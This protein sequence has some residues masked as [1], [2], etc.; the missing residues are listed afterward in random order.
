MKKE[1]RFIERVMIEYY[2]FIIYGFNF[3]FFNG[4]CV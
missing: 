2:Y 3:F 4:V 1:H